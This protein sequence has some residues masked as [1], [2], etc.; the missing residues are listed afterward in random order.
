MLFDE[1]MQ[2]WQSIKWH[3]SIAVMLCV[4]GHIPGKPANKGLCVCGSGVT[5]HVVSVRTAR[6]LCQQVEP[7]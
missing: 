7:K 6:M 2:R 3:G 1:S 4:I 5:E